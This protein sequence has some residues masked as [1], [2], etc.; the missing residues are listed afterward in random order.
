M[1]SVP[2]A[3]PGTDSAPVLGHWGSCL[4]AA[5][6]KVDWFV[7]TSCPLLT[8]NY[9]SFISLSFSFPLF[10]PVFSSLLM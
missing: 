2:V 1:V 6:C 8:Y 9:C 10:V 4:V 5:V 3:S 7:A